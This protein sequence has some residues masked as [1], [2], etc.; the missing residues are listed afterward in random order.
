MGKI[1][2]EMQSAFL[3]GRYILDGPLIINEIL[4]WVKRMGKELFLFKIYFEKAYDN[5]HW[6]F[7]LSVMHKMNFPEVWCRWIKG[8]L[9]LTRSSIFVN[10]SPTFEFGCGKG[11]RQRDPISP[12]LFIIVMKAFSCMIRKE[13]DSGSFDGVGLPNDGPILS[14]LLYADDAKVMVEWSKFNFQA[15]KR[16]LRIFHLCYGL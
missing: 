2:Y 6:E 15:L 1:T 4:S 11:I 8:V 7:L 13:N 16:I 5:V 10:G 14:H 12:F 3:S 9:S